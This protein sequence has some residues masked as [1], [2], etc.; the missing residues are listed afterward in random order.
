MAN[1]PV[2]W[3]KQHL[4]TEGWRMKGAIT[5]TIAKAVSFFLG[6]IKVHIHFYTV[7][8]VPAAPTGRGLPGGKGMDASRF[9][10]TPVTMCRCGHIARNIDDL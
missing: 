9:M 2:A 8:N 3:K 7:I 1:L 10:F 4:W 5:D 6:G